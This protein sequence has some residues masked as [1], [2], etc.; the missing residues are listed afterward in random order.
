M[1]PVVASVLLLVA[2]AVTAQKQERATP[3]QIKRDVKALYAKDPAV[4]SEAL[5][6][7]KEAGTTAVPYLV[8]VLNDGRRANTDAVLAAIKILG[9]LRAKQAAPALVRA[10]DF[11]TT[12]ESSVLLKGDSRI[13]QEYPAVGALVQ[14]G[15][16]AVPALKAELSLGHASREELVL[17]T[18]KIIGGPS[19]A[20]VVT[21]YI[22][23]LERRLV[24][25]KQILQALTATAK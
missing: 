14:I 3:E 19:A 11:N 9:D 6:R 4:R 8:V 7:L 16:D 20:R 15:S 2:S 18:L 10:I 22:S 5:A 1:C 17:R 21:D 23:D 25:A 13:I 12:G 24:R